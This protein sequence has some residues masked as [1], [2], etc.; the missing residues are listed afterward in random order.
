MAVNMAVLTVKVLTH[1]PARMDTE[2]IEMDA[3]AMVSD[4][5]AMIGSL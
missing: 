1:V 4:S 5:T 2:L 3:H